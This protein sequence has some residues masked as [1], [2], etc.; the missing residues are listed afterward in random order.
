MTPSLHYYICFESGITPV[1]YRIFLL[2]N[3]Y[4]PFLFG[5]QTALRLHLKMSS[6]LEDVYDFLLTDDVAYDYS[7]VRSLARCDSVDATFIFVVVLPT[8]FFVGR[9]EYKFAGLPQRSASDPGLRFRPNIAKRE[10]ST[11]YVLHWLSQGPSAKIPS[12]QDLCTQRIAYSLLSDAIALQDDYSSKESYYSLCN[13]MALVS[14]FKTMVTNVCDLRKFP[15][16]KLLPGSWPDA[17]GDYDCYDSL[18]CSIVDELLC[19]LIVRDLYRD[20]RQNWIYLPLHMHKNLPFLPAFDHAPSDLKRT[21]VR[22]DS[23]ELYWLQKGLPYL[24]T[25]ILEKG[26]G[27]LA[28]TV[29]LSS[30]IAEGVA[31]TW[32]RTLHGVVLAVFAVLRRVGS[33]PLDYLALYPVHTLLGYVRYNAAAT[34]KPAI[35]GIRT[36]LNLLRRINGI[37]YKATTYN[38]AAVNLI[39]GNTPQTTRRL[40]RRYSLDPLAGATAPRNV[41]DVHGFT[42]TAIPTVRHLLRECHYYVSGTYSPSDPTIVH[43]GPLFRRLS[44]TLS[45]LALTMEKDATFRDQDTYPCPASYPS[46]SNRSVLPLWGDPSRE[47]LLVQAFVSPHVDLLDLRDN[48]TVTDTDLSLALMGMRHVSTVFTRGASRLSLENVTL[49]AVPRQPEFDQERSW[50]RRRHVR[51][52]LV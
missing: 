46:M 22:K 3:P 36:Q 35:Q 50:S 19:A 7:T 28:A 42:A 24:S 10:K 49:I 6:T 40:L 31:A 48:K 18:A 5:A 9:Q 11:A 21:K 16:D 33:H 8:A 34:D 38:E 29:M 23:P 52:R 41:F 45:P 20:V 1:P 26:R 30:S 2:Q 43:R 47:R 17:S 4:Y 27:R 25:M 32:D 37:A 44:D 51:R 14:K 15:P 13:K 12:L 39:F